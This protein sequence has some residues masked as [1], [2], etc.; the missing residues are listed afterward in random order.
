MKII[1]EAI[2]LSKFKQNTALV[3]APICKKSWELAG[4]NYSGQTELL[5]DEFKTKNVGMLFTAKS[6]ITG[7][8][9]NT[10]LA[11]THIPLNKISKHIINDKN[12]INSKLNRSSRRY[13]TL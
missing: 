6:P 4:H 7:W 2:K 12:L 8:R 10:L 1:K 13:I 3:T 9:F 5:A 11:T